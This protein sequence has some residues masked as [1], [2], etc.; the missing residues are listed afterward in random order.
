MNGVL[1]VVQYRKYPRDMIIRAK[2]ML[3][4]LGVP[5]VGVVLNNIN[6]MRDDYYYYYHSYYSNY[7]SPEASPGAQPGEK[8]AA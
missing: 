4:T 7:Y 6:I 8:G 3:D 1:L 5:Q 2:Q